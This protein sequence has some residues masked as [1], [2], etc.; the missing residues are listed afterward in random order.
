MMKVLKL[1][2]YSELPKNYT[3]I[4]EYFDDTKCWYLKGKLHRE[5]G[6]ACEWSDGQKEWWLNSKRHREDG[7]A[8]EYASGRKEWWLNGSRHR[9]NGPATETANGSK[10]WFLNGKYLFSLPSESQP[11]I[12]IEEFMDEES[13][14]QIKVLTQ[15]GIEIWPFLPGLKE[16]AE[17]WE[18]VK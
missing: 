17:N 14:G 10:E 16:L 13:K 11:F 3:G 5:D 6:P 4:I 1:K 12:L 9:E 8:I 2:K 18:G 7:P 15:Q